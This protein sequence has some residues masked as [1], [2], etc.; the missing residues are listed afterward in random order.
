V[1][2]AELT[3]IEQQVNEE[4]LKNLEMQTDIMNID[5][6]LA[7]GALAFFGD[8]YP[9]ANVRVVTIPDAAAA[10]GFYSKELCGGTH[11]HRTG[12]IGVFKILREE[13]TAAGVRRIEAISGDRALAEYQKAL[14][15]LRTA[16]GLL[17]V[18]ED[19]VI[20]ALERQ[21]E[22]TKHLEK[23]L[24]GLK[25]KAAGSIA[26][27]LLAEIRTVKDVRFLAAKVDG[28]DRESLRQLTDTLR[29]KLGSGVIVL[30]SAD[31]GKVALITAV[32]KDL[33]SKLHAGKIVQEL[34]KLV[35]GTGGGRPD[36]AEAG[37][38]DTSGIEKAIGNVY[39]LL[40]RLL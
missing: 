3:E 37:G 14:S 22:S 8:K 10:R 13:S 24:E 1:D 29:Q 39:P 4:I 17:N 12:E 9:E 32:T 25:R 28:F 35:G 19:D 31:D 6:A 18:P 20:A 16:A 21:F 5:D 34:A 38:K 23:Q 11:V 15:T 33:T 27:S 26:D 30:A 2:A 7:S 40:E 36:M